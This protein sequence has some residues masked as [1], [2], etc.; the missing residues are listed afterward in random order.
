MK[1]QSFT[2]RVKQAALGHGSLLWWAAKNGRAATVECHVA[3]VEYLAL[4]LAEFF[5]V[6]APH[7]H[8]GSN[9]GTTPEEVAI[10]SQIRLLLSKLRA[11]HAG[12][13]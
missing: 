12:L 13:A 8:F 10:D 2:F 5:D 1:V 3:T 9:F 7:P 4:E 6:S 11:I